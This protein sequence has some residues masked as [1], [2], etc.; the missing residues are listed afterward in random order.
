MHPPFLLAK[1]TFDT[2]AT[3]FLYPACTEPDADCERWRVDD[4]LHEVT[5]GMSR[6]RADDVPWLGG[7]KSP[8]LSDVPH[9]VWA[10]L[11]DADKL[12]GQVQLRLQRRH[13]AP[14]ESTLGTGGGQAA[15]RRDSGRDAA[16]LTGQRA[17]RGRRGVKSASARDR[18]SFRRSPLAY[19][20]GIPAREIP[21][22]DRGWRRLMEAE[23]MLG[24]QDFEVGA[25]SLDYATRR[26]AQLAVRHLSDWAEDGLRAAKK[27]CVEPLPVPPWPRARG[28]RGDLFCCTESQGAG[29]AAG[30]RIVATPHEC[31]Y[32]RVD[33]VRSEDE[34]RAPLAPLARAALR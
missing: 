8:P 1:G 13:A 26:R 19:L 18:E 32:G 7:R 24:D 5:S 29:G 20:A 21:A 6:L 12:L 33:I 22:M 3:S 25:E 28:L 4:A 27:C 10:K 14:G 11:A 15:A 16:A 17:A 9:S 23:K 31:K 30:R 34:C 2:L